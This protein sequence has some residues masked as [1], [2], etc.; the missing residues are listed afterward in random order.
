MG[1]EEEK[2]KSFYPAFLLGSAGGRSGQMSAEEGD[3]PPPEEEAPPSS[4]DA[5]PPYSEGAAPSDPG[6]E[7][8]PPPEEEAPPPSS[9]EA[10]PF[11]EGASFEEDNASLFE[12]GPTY[13]LS[14]YM[15]LISSD[16]RIVIPDDDEAY[17]HRV[18]S[19]PPPRIVQSMLSDVLSQSSRSSS[20]YRRSMSGIP[21][22]QE[23][24]K[25]RQARFRDARESRKMKI[26]PSYKYIFE[27]LSE[28]LGLD[29]TTVEELILD[30][31]SLE[32]FNVFFMKDG[33]KTLKFLY[34]E[35]DVPGLGSAYAYGL[36]TQTPA[37]RVPRRQSIMGVDVLFT[38]LDASKGLLVGIRNMLANIFLPAILATNNWGALNQSKQGESEKH[39][40][41][42]TIN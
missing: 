33:C 40:F 27:I 3:P 1:E 4:G 22:L 41:T 7:A 42:E 29:L 12:K 37:L 21:S 2:T 16:E 32:A 28:T 25:E 10:P 15:N 13:S 18:R 11:P 19:R 5:A 31:P 17:P 36:F 8:P 20:R 24:L 9:E 6:N 38:V 30:C 39:I 23:T 26:D 34:Q 35:G 14:D